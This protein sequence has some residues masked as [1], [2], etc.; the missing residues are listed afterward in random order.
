VSGNTEIRRAAFDYARRGLA[1]LPLRGGPGKLAKRPVT[2]NGLNDATTDPAQLERWFS[3]GGHTAIG[4]TLP[5]NAVV[6]DVDIRNGG[7]E[8]L[9]RWCVERGDGWFDVPPLAV[10]GGGGFH[11]WYRRPPGALRHPTPGPKHAIE[12]LRA[13]HYVVMPPTMTNNQ[14]VWRRTLPLDLGHLPDMPEWLRALC[15]QPIEQ[16]EASI[17]SAPYVSKGDDRLDRV[18][19]EYTTWRQLLHAAGWI[20]VRGDGDSDGS[21]W[22]HPTS[23]NAYS[24]TVRHSCLFVYSPNTPFAVTETEKPK[25]VTLF[26]AIAVYEFGGDTPEGRR[27]ARKALV[28]D[29]DRALVDRW[30]ATLDKAEP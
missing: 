24:A 3:A 16:W 12:C 14:Y 1:C 28:G 27:A 17:P 5:D 26:S 21:R 7:W 20:L 2:T 18:A 8:A 29:E 22:R 4:V 11:L 10:T 30:L 6:I 13:P 9:D 19:H 15:L 25:G 23:D